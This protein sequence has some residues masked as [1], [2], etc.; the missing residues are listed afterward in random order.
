MKLIIKL[1]LVLLVAALFLPLV[2]KGPSGEPIMTIDDWLEAP[3]IYF[4][5]EVKH[6]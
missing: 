1:C 6:P 4:E 2:V 5:A 3:A